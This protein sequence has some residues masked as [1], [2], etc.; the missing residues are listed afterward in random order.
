MSCLEEIT[1]TFSGGG[2]GKP[3]LGEQEIRDHG[4]LSPKTGNQSSGKSR[5]EK[6]TVSHKQ[7][8]PSQMVL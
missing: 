7:E 5:A 3:R 1:Y 6:G 4:C 8:S 2:K